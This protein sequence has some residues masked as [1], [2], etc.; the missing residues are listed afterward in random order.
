M[1]CLVPPRCPG[2]PCKHHFVLQPQGWLSTNTSLVPDAKRGDR[3]AKCTWSAAGGLR[4][5]HPGVLSRGGPCRE[6]HVGA[7]S[8]GA[9]VQGVIIS[10]KAVKP[11]EKAHLG[12]VSN[13]LPKGEPWVQHLPPPAALT[14]GLSAQHQF[15]RCWGAQAGEGEPPTQHRGDRLL[16]PKPP[17][18]PS[19]HRNVS[20]TEATRQLLRHVRPATSSS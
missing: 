6:G 8:L 17:V 3:P 1:N 14:G 15:M 10:C 16:G 19:H 9:R 12:H 7:P 11:P 18:C 13:Q 4:R 2:C 5:G 20:K